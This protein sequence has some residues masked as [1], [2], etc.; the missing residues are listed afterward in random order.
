MTNVDMNFEDSHSEIKSG[1]K[2]IFLRNENNVAI[3]VHIFWSAFF[4]SAI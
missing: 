3:L 4:V 1:E 2:I